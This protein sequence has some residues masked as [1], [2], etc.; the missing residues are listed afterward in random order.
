MC[1]ARNIQVTIQNPIATFSFY[2][3]TLVDFLSVIREMNLL[4]SI[5]QA[6]NN[7]VPKV[8]DLF[9]LH[10]DEKT[11][12]KSEIL[13]SGDKYIW[14][15]CPF[16]NCSVSLLNDEIKIVT[17]AECPSCYRLFC[18]QCKIPWH[19]GHNCQRFQ[20]RENRLLKRENHSL[21]T[22]KMKRSGRRKSL[23]SLINQIKTR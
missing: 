12:K 10:D 22:A 11:K 15:N 14:G 18:A 16:K 3:T 19:G 1:T 5:K 23:W 20:Q 9:S 6:A 2:D 8:E 4:N 17:N 21:K 13:L 7:F